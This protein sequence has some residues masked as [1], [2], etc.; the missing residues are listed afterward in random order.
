MPITSVTTDPIALRMTVVAKFTVPVQ[1]LWD[2]YAAPRQ[3]DRFWGPPTYPARFTRHD[4]YAGGR[5]EYAMTGPDGD[6]SRGYWEAA[7][8][9]CGAGAVPRRRG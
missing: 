2:A 3:L 4:M 7:A 6:V 1:R 8:T 5:S 9:G